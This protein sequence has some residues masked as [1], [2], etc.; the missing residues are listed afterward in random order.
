MRLFLL[1]STHT[2]IHA[3]R[4]RMQD[5]VRVENRMVLHHCHQ[6]QLH[7]VLLPYT[8]QLLVAESTVNPEQSN[9]III[10]LPG[11]KLLQG[12]ALLASEEKDQVPMRADK[13]DLSSDTPLCGLPHV[14]LPHDHL[15]GLLV[16]KAAHSL[17]G[18]VIEPLGR[19]LHNCQQSAELPQVAGGLHLLVQRHH[20]H[21]FA[22]RPILPLVGVG[23]ESS[24]LITHPCKSD[25]KQGTLPAD[26][27]VE[28]ANLPP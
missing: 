7:V 21:K 25:R 22:G 1:L 23:Q 17:Q 18:P 2:A 5:I 24:M 16:Q 26:P 4:H 8:V 13:V 27:E 15:Y 12:P 6:V 20:L 3:T 28:G 10:R 11:H 9:C 14:I 19:Y